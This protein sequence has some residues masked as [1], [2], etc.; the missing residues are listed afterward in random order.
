ML[1]YE[2]L[3]LEFKGDDFVK[4]VDGDYSSE[5]KNIVNQFIGTLNCKYTKYK[6]AVLVSDSEVV[7]LYQSMGYT[8]TPIDYSS[9]LTLVCNNRYEKLDFNRCVLYNFVVC[10]EYRNLMAGIKLV[11]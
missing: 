2:T 1:C 10:S 6:F 9:D 3:G 5:L 4:V 11:R 8:C 7:S